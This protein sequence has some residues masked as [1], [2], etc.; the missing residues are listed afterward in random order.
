MSFGLPGPDKRT[1]EIKGA[2]MCLPLMIRFGLR[3]T[4]ADTQ[5]IELSQGSTRR[6][7][8]QKVK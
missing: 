1:P 7:R 8:V 3:L 2:A 6:P 4:E 5:L